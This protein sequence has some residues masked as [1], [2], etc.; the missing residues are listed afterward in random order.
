MIRTALEYVVW[1]HKHNPRE[2]IMSDMLQKLPHHER[3]KIKDAV[4]HIS[5]SVFEPDGWPRWH[6]CI[7]CNG[8]GELSRDKI[9]MNGLAGGGYVE[10][11]GTECCAVCDGTGKLENE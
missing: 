9:V 6:E 11:I 7:E 1:V 2:Q 8:F 10:E 5:E 4:R 3:E